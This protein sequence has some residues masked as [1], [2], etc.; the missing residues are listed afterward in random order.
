[1]IKFLDYCAYGILILLFLF[2]LGTILF[3]LVKF[4]GT[5]YLIGFILVLASISWLSYRSIN[6]YKGE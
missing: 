4:M 6:K 2:S 5:F 3:I 1:M